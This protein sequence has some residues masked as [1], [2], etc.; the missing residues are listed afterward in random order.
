[1]PDGTEILAAEDGKIIEA[2]DNFN[3]WGPSEKFID[4]LNYL[5]IQH[6]NGEYSQYCHLAK[7]SFQNT[8]LRV[9]LNVKK[10]EVIGI[11]GKTGWTDR[12]HLHFIVF[13]VGPIIGSP[14]TFYSLRIRFEK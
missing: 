14:Y 10:G 6:P 5:T 13:K 11:V 7:N 3:T 9:G 2:I 4:Q 1:M 8:G 12:D